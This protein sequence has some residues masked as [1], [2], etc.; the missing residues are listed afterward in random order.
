[1]AKK[2]TS[3]LRIIGGKWRSRMLPIADVE[4]LRP[5]TDRV[6]ETVFNWLQPYLYG[7]KVLD[8][9][10]GSGVLGFEA[11]SRE[12]ASATLIE[13]NKYAAKNLTE[14]ANTLKAEN[15]VIWQTD[16]LAWL[17]SCT[18][19]FNVIF[20]D[21]PFNKG[22]LPN[23]INL[24]HEHNLIEDNGWVYIESE[25]DLSDLPIPRHWHLFREKKAGMVVLRLF[26]VE[27]E[28]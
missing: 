19:S 6:R 11:L 15:A 20:L 9:F 7:A 22:L 25:S 17:A 27:P 4:G 16:A 1:M 23:C 10:A 13:K 21:P 3:R 2:T 26:Q 14:N 28:A 24:I 5:T 12:A 8:V 18:Q